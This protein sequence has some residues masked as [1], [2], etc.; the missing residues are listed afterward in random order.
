MGK[1]KNIQVV[2][3]LKDKIHQDTALILTDYTGITH[4]QL[5]NLRNTVKKIGGDFQIV[6]NSLLKMILGDVFKI[7]SADLEKLTGPTAILITPTADTTPLAELYKKGKE[8]DALSIKW[9]IWEGK[10]I[11][12]ETALKLATLP[13]KEVLLTQLVSQLKNSQTRLVFVLKGNLQKLALL[14]SEIQKKKGL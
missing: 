10:K 5:E 7:E 13:S 4:Q 6:K 12:K 1:K 11:E 2:A 8:L 3:S 9:G 14:L